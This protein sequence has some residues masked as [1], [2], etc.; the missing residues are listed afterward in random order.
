[1]GEIRDR[2]LD[3]PIAAAGAMRSFATGATRNEDASKPD[4]EG[5]LST[6]A[7]ASFARYMNKHRKQADGQLRA[8]DNWQKGIPL[9]SYMKSMLR[10]VMDL[11]MHHRGLS[12][13]ASEP[14]EDAINGV[15]F[16]IQGYSHETEKAKLAP[17][18]PINLGGSSDRK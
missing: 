2:L 4:Y 18:S 12:A 17:S 1:M 10:H 15:M 5:F 6:L 7:L 9:D 3:T 16:N 8:S 11:W 14:L 13:L